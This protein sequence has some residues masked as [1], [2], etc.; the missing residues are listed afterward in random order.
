LPGALLL[1]DLAGHLLPVDPHAEP[2]DARLVR[3]REGVECLHDAVLGVLEDLMDL[4]D[5]DAVVDR[6]PDVVLLDLEGSAQAAVGDEE[7][8]CLHPRTS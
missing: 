4:G 7:P 8:G 3:H 1:D 6:H 2:G 5:G